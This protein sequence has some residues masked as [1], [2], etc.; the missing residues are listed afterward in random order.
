LH[1]TDV[2]RR[3]D[4]VAYPPDTTEKAVGTVI[5]EAELLAADWTA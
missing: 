5:K 4:R 1:A 2:L 3:E